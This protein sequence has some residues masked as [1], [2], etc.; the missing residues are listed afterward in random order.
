MERFLLQRNGFY[1]QTYHTPRSLFARGWTR[2]PLKGFIRINKV[3]EKIMYFYSLSV[4]YNNRSP[5]AGN[6]SQ[7][8]NNCHRRAAILYELTKDIL[9]NNSVAQL[10][11]VMTRIMLCSYGYARQIINKRKKAAA[12][13]AILMAMRIRRYGAEPIAQWGRSRATLDATGRRHWEIICPVSSQRT[14]WSSILA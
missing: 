8:G 2:P 4:N 10:Y 13:L 14:P 6:D 11:F 7:N 3:K 5:A 9:T 12:S 1:G